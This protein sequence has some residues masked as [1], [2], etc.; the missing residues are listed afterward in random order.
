MALPIYGKTT[1]T[2]FSTRITLSKLT[3]IAVGKFES[4]RTKSGDLM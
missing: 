1:I 4:F 2:I 3:Y